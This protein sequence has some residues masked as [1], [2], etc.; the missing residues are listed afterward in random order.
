MVP[1]I[2]VADER[3]DDDARRHPGDDTPHTAPWR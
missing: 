2:C 3:T 1:T